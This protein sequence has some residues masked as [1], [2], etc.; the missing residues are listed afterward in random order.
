M[1]QV[2]TTRVALVI[3]VFND[4]K[5]VA[6]VLLSLDQLPSLDGISLHVILV[7][8]G[9]F[10]PRQFLLDPRR[11]L[12]IKHLEVLDLV[13]NL[14]HQRAIAVG[15]AVAARLPGIGGVLVMDGDG[16]DRPEDIAALLDAS[17]RHPR[18][19]VCARRSKRSEP[20]LFRAFYL[21][22]KLVFRILTGRQI[23]F[24]NFC[25]IP[26][27]ALRT[28]VYSPATW[29]HLAA[30][31]LRSRVPVFG[32]DT[33]RGR[34]FAGQSSMSFTA[35]ML[36]GMSAISVYADLVTVRIVL[37]MV[38]FAGVAVC[39]IIVAV[40]IRLFTDLAIPGWA[41]SVIASMM[42]MLVESLVFATV[43]ALMLLN[44]RSAKPVTPALDALAYLGSS[45][46]VV[47]EE[48]R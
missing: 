37:A 21:C 12:R 31:I 39:G 13:C 36:H 11:C 43:A 29:N 10:Q 9:S 23:D 25:F 20:P 32:V 30:S 33:Q 19:I 8:D 48:A 22:Y 35:L 14:G 46:G 2:A 40:A 4:W 38:G 44:A 42:A 5:S 1:D 15:L 18:H 24:G 17:A 7:D 16:E 26:A 6:E 3:P 47:T 34:R 41:S 27:S 28:V 45:E